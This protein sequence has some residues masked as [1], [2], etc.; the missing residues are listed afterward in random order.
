MSLVFTD[1]NTKEQ[2]YSVVYFDKVGEVQEANLLAK[3]LKHAR[4]EARKCFR[5]RE[6]DH[7]CHRCKNES[8]NNLFP[9]AGIHNLSS[10]GTAC[11]KHNGIGGKEVSWICYPALNCVKWQEGYESSPDKILQKIHDR[12]SNNLQVKEMVIVRGSIHIRS[13]NLLPF[14]LPG[15]GEGT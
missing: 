9:A 15:K 1:K 8:Y 3:N 5:K 4:L 7:G 6:Y 11:N 12:W 10:K 13:H 2:L 14:Q